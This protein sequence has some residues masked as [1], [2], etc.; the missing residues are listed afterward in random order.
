MMPACALEWSR[1]G[2]L[3][4]QS[5]GQALIVRSSGRLL[6]PNPHLLSKLLPTYGVIALAPSNVAVAFPE[7]FRFRFLSRRCSNAGAEA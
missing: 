1:I 6:F 5:I 3:R 2:S 4:G 7:P